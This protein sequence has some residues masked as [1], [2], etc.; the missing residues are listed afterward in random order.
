MKKREA[1]REEEQKKEE[2]AEAK[3]IAKQVCIRKWKHYYPSN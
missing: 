2:E 1:L 3:R